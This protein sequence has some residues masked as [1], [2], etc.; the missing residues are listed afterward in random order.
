MEGAPFLAYGPRSRTRPFLSISMPEGVVYVVR[1]FWNGSC[2]PRLILQVVGSLTIQTSFREVP[3][4][5]LYTN[6]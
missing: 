2:S 5:L 6:R 3:C 1:S 4:Y